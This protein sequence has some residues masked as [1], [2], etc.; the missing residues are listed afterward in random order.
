MR[1]RLFLLGVLLAVLATA[2]D[3]G[4]TGLCINAETMSPCQKDSK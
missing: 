4:P 2:C 3:Y 1:N